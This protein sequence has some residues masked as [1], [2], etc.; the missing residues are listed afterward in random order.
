MPRKTKP[1]RLLLRTRTDRD[2][3][4]VILDGGREKS[5]GTGH[6]EEAEAHLEAYLAGKKRRSGPNEAG[7]LMVS[8]ILATYGEERAP[9]TADP[10]RIGYAIDALIQF[11]GDMPVSAIKGATCRL[12]AKSR[13]R[14]V[15]SREVPVSDGTVR[16]ELGVLRAALKHCEREGYL[17]A[18]PVVTLPKPPETNQQA[19]DRNEV[20]KM[21]WA[22]RRLGRRRKDRDFRHITRFILTSI[23]TGT[24]KSATLGL[25]L[26]GPYTA[27]GWFDLDAGLLYRKGTQEASTKKRRTPARLP[28]QLLG[29]ARRW[30][31]SGGT[32][33]VDYRGSRV[34]DIKTAW[35]HV[36]EEADLGWNPTPHTLKHT[37][38]TWAIQGGASIA[39]AAGFFATSAETIER[40]YW[41]MSPHFQQGALAA[42]EGKRA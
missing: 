26:S 39:D 12:Y 32:W 24:R 9:Y 41:H 23:Y 16:R 40:V 11:W 25:R 10:S 30:K 20:A 34:A 27:G 6:L 22:C 4:Y 15:G 31:A 21:L 37:A 2:P 19:L 14:L 17:I 1:A 18:A 35:S 33:A 36:L 8:E 29:H 28:R 3:V 5:T 42:I 7:E 13:T 38:I